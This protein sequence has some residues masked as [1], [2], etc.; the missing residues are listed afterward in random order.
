MAPSRLI[1]AAQMTIESNDD[2][3]FVM[4]LGGV[5]VGSKKSWV[6]TLII[7]IKHGICDGLTTQSNLFGLVK[8]RVV[9]WW[10]FFSRP[11]LYENE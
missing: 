10:H 8:S 5:L 3:A 7:R 2:I 9:D 1:R 11:L 4:G 6:I